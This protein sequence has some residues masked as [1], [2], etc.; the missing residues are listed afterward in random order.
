MLPGEVLLLKYK[1]LRVLKNA[2]ESCIFLVEHIDLNSY[3]I[4]KK[5][6]ASDAKYLKEIELLKGLKHDNIPLLVDVIVEESWIYIVREYIDGKTLDQYIDELGQ[7]DE[8][9]GIRIGISLCKIVEFFHGFQNPIIIRDIK[10]SNIIIA[11]DGTLKLIDFSIAKKFSTDS[12]RDTEYLGTKGFAAIEQYGINSKDKCDVQTDVFGIGATLY[13]L[14]SRQDLGRPPYRFYPLS[15]FRNDLSLNIEGILLK[16]CQLKKVDR[17][18]DVNEFREALQSCI[19]E[20]LP[21]T[22]TT[23]ID[24]QNLPTL[25]L[26]GIKNGVGTTHQC[27]GISRF[28]RK[29][30]LSV[31]LIDKSQDQMLR[32]LEYHEDAYQDQGILYFQ[33]LPIL[34]EPPFSQ[35]NTLQSSFYEKRKSR[36]SLIKSYEEK[37]IRQ[38]DVVIVDGG[39]LKEP[40]TLIQNN[41]STEFQHLI[42]A[43]LNPWEIEVIEEF[44]LTASHASIDYGISFATQKQV[45]EFQNSIPDKKII[46]LPISLFDEQEDNDSYYLNLLHP[47]IIAKIKSKTKEEK[48]WGFSKEIFSKVRKSKIPFRTNIK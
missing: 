31:L 20:D 36:S 2:Q 10:P 7:I 5:V 8:Q 6:N 15:Q 30:G 41:H 25:F 28:L 9:E 4:I 45:Q 43:T 3:W 14:F 47:S 16:A 33:G 37:L 24:R 23:Q 17:Y 19:K 48:P 11:R 13:F 21:N 38:S 39:S 27:L 32:N 26:Q 34:F 18:T 29:C 12:I 40:G 42:I 1:I 35:N 22:I 46:R 44:V